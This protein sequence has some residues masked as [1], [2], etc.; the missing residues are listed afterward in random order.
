MGTAVAQ[1]LSR[2]ATNRNVAGSIP[3]SVSRIFIDIKSFQSHY[4]PGVDSASNRNEYEEYLVEVKADG[5]F[6]T[7]TFYEIRIAAIN[8]S[9]EVFVDSGG[10]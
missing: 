4:G 6:T 9:V 7:T 10:R 1:W 8:I 5:A 2:G 3:A